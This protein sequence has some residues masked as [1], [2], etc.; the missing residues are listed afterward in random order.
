[1]IIL[2]SKFLILNYITFDPFSNILEI[3]TEIIKN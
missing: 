1:M 2:S 3:T